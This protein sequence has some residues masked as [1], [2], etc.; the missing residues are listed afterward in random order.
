MKDLKTLLE[1]K[2]D[3]IMTFPKWAEYLRIDIEKNTIEFLKGNNVNKDIK[4][5]A[6]GCGMSTVGPDDLIYV[7]II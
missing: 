7:C 4:E 1:Y 5:K 6:G 2:D 3:S